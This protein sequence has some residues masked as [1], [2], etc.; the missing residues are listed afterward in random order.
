MKLSTEQQ[1]ICRK[2]FDAVKLRLAQTDHQFRHDAL[3]NA[4]EC[5]IIDFS[6]RAPL[7]SRTHSL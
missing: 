5:M 1:E 4:V 7:T 2:N 6:T 3:R